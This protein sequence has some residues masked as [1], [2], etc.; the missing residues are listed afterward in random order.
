M[1]PFR[2]G[3]SHGFIFLVLNMPW[4]SGIGSGKLKVLDGTS[5]PGAGFKTSLKEC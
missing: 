4:I 5:G 2:A 3:K 1:L